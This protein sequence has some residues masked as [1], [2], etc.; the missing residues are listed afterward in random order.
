MFEFP[1]NFS[2]KSVCMIQSKKVAAVWSAV[3]AKKHQFCD[4]LQWKMIILTMFDLCLLIVK[5][6]FNRSLL[7][8]PK[9][10]WLHL[11]K[12]QEKFVLGVS[13]QVSL[14]PACFKCLD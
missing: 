3:P 5:S 2:Y 4:N 1:L 7:G 14:K 9:E 12:M 8:V 13:S 6:F 10:Y 11:T